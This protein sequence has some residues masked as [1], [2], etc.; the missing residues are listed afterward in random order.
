M[1]SVTSMNFFFEAITD[2][3]VLEYQS[4]ASAP[5]YFDSL[6]LTHSLYYVFNM[7]TRPTSAGNDKKRKKETLKNLGT[8]DSRWRLVETLYLVIAT[9]VDNV[10]NF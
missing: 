3:N 5:G 4:C 8:T 6:L 2:A 10:T 1:F 7:K 9:H